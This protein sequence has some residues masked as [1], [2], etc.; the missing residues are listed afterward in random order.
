M[1]AHSSLANRR[2]KDWLKFLED[3][4]R[5]GYLFSLPLVVMEDIRQKRI[6]KKGMNEWLHSK[7]LLNA[8][9]RVVTMPNNDTLYSDAWLDLT[10]GP[11]TIKVPAI[12]D[13]YYSLALMDYYTNNFEIISS[14]TIGALGGEFNIYPPLSDIPD[15]DNSAI[16]S[17]T[18]YVWALVRILIDG[19]EDLDEVRALQDQFE[20][21]AKE[22]GHHPESIESNRLSEWNEYFEASNLLIRCNY[23]RA[24][25]RGIISRLAVAGLG[26]GSGF[27]PLSF[28]DEER[29]AIAKGVKKAR[30][31]LDS[32]QAQYEMRSDGWSYFS[33]AI[34][35][36]RN[37]YSLRAAVAIHS[38]AALVPEEATYMRSY[39]EQG[40]EY[41]DGRQNWRLHFSAD[42]LPPVEAFWSLTLYEPTGEGLFFFYENSENR[43]AIGDRTKELSYN[44]DGSLDLYI[45]NQDPGVSK[46]SNWLP[47]PSGPFVLLFRAY[48]AKPEMISGVYFLPRIEKVQR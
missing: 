11:V 4:A 28:G 6:K 30:D 40:G 3:T 15:G 5:D 27:D 1:T 21:S 14:R 35:D 9:S 33:G 8:N 45:G 2:R 47:G 38:L 29:E 25:D 46:R 42:K 39:N 13:R 10:S 41:L 36:F 19:D 24:S 22:T 44:Q 26:D 31:A 16:R 32:I 18:P 37:K 17:P 48:L 23:P 20:I 7:K 43:Y 12:I 34:G